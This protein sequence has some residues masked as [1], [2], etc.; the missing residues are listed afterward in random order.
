MQAF[1]KKSPKKPVFESLKT[2]DWFISYK[3]SLKQSFQSQQNPL[4]V[5]IQCTSNSGSPRNITLD[6]KPKPSH[7]RAQSYN[8]PTPQPKYRTLYNKL[9]SRP[10]SPVKIARSSC[11]SPDYIPRSHKFS[12]PSFS[13]LGEKADR[14]SKLKA[15][16]ITQKSYQSARPFSHYS[17]RVQQNPKL[18][19]TLLG[20]YVYIDS[21]PYDDFNSSR[22]KL[23]SFSS[24]KKEKAHS[25]N[26]KQRKEEKDYF[27]I[28]NVQNSSMLAGS[29]S[30]SKESLS[31]TSFEINLPRYT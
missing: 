4:S 5:G 27:K 15:P 14:T 1:Q 19:R 29:K 8:F 2:L 24:N 17:T 25:K 6:P 18:E 13:I 30:S 26:K 7:K 16:S 12:Q 3:P 20:K 10:S 9:R 28:I 22:H 21:N 31:Q 11:I 23:L